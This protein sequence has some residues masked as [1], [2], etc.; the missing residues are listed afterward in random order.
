PGGGSALG[1]ED[2]DAGRYPLGVRLEEPRG[3]GRAQR[4]VEH[5]LERRTPAAGQARREG[6]VVAHDGTGAD[7]DGVELVAPG[8]DALAGG[9]AADPARL[10]ARRGGLAVERRRGLVE[11]ERAAEPPGGE[12]GLAQGLRSE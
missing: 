3:G 1:R 8:V 6:G 11:H 12:V 5:D 10:A 7:G 2:D 9:L 4:A